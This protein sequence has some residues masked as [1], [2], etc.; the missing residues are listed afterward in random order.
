MQG[1]NNTQHLL[2]YKF[3]HL[4]MQFHN[5]CC[6]TFLKMAFLKIHIFKSIIILL[7][8]HIFQPQ[9]YILIYPRMCD[10]CTNTYV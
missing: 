10:S 9:A 7:K 3:Y 4:C 2:N 5:D 8:E 1:F 6:I